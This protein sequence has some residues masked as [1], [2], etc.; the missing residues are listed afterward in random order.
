MGFGSAGLRWPRGRKHPGNLKSCLAACVVGRWPDGVD[1]EMVGLCLV[2]RPFYHTIIRRG[3][4]VNV[5]KKQQATH[6]STD[7]W[8][9]PSSGASFE[10]VVL[11]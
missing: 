1:S 6:S 2:N 7:W 8:N 3:E 5:W 4:Q 11:T 9:V 10:C